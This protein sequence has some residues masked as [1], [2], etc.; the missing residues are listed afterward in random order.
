MRIILKPGAETFEVSFYGQAIMHRMAQRD[1]QNLVAVGLAVVQEQVPKGRMQGVCPIEV[2]R[3][4]HVRP[5]RVRG[6]R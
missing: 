1:D 4:L 2:E 6:C 3:N 5:F